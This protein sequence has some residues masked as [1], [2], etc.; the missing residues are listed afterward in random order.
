MTG[1]LLSIFRSPAQ[2]SCQIPVD[3]RGIAPV[4]S[5]HIQNKIENSLPHSCRKMRIPDR[6]CDDEAAPRI[7]RC[8]DLEHL[9]VSGPREIVFPAEAAPLY[10][11]SLETSRALERKE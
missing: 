3:S 1:A 8:N 5:E 11:I 2:C 6:A 7:E 4:V 9:P 10:K